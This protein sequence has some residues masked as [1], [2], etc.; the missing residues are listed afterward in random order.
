MSY[1][2]KISGMKA[3][4]IKGTTELSGETQYITTLSCL[5]T[6]PKPFKQ[7]YRHIM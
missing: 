1:V 2:L 7:I 4:K 6:P 5:T 3:L